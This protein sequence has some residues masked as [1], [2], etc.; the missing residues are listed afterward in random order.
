MWIS[1][2]VSSFD[3]VFHYFQIHFIFFKE[4]LI[5]YLS[6]V[7]SQPYASNHFRF[8]LHHLSVLMGLGPV[9][10]ANMQSEGAS[11]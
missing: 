8:P 3:F 1:N 10:T 9:Q 4:S 11:R 5:L 2:K 7:I 6:F